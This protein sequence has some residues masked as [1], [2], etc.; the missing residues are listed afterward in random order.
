[1]LATSYLKK[2]RK[3]TFCESVTSRKHGKRQGNVNPVSRNR[4][5]SEISEHSAHGTVPH[6]REE[7]EKGR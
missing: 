1:M 5:H 7:E 3:D 2:E 4:R 6:H